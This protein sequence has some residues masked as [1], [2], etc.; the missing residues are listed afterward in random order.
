MSEDR[1]LMMILH[2]NH[3]SEEEKELARYL[4]PRFDWKP[5]LRRSDKVIHNAMLARIVCEPYD[6]H[7]IY[8]YYPGDVVTI[9]VRLEANGLIVLDDKMNF[10]LI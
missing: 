3:C 7:R 9:M 1:N 8:G 5:R 2:Y 4:R 10:Y 6:L